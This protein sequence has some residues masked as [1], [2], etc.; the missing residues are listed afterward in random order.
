MKRIAPL[1]LAL[2]FGAVPAFAQSKPP[3]A[4]DGTEVTEA[5]QRFARG[6]DLYKEGS[7]DAAFAEFT[8]AYELVPN[9]RVLFNL[10]QVQSE[11]HDYVASLQLFE[12]YLK[13]GGNEISAE[14]REQVGREITA[15]KGRV[16]Q[17]TVAADVEGAELLI[18]GVSAGT[19]PLKEPVLVSAG[20][21]QIQI[22]KSG[23]ETTTRTETIAGGDAPHYDFKLVAVPGAAASAAATPA[24]SEL[25][26][27]PP[28]PEKASSNAPFW[29]TLAT[30]AVFTGGAITFG[31]LAHNADQKLDKELDTFPMNQSSVDDARS[32]LKQD[33]LLTDIMTGAAV[34]SGGFCLYFALSHSS[35]HSSSGQ[36]KPANLRIG[37]AGTGVR[38]LGNF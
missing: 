3:S 11:R 13:E 2:T 34:V 20:V 7:F 5:R 23:Y 35:G 16:A 30:T 27:L 32:T 28:E 33:A 15:L 14:R 8:K 21:R 17:L 10:A 18:D 31:V 4:A 25:A 38:V 12:K 9:Y 24:S 6:V 37:A 29:I 1:L 26:G 36:S 22:R 19:L